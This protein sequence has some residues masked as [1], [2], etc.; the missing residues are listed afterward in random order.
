MIFWECASQPPGAHTGGGF[1]SD[2]SSSS[3][4][5][6]VPTET[7]NCTAMRV[8]GGMRYTVPE[9]PGEKCSYHWEDKNMTHL[10]YNHPVA[11]PTVV[12]HSD[13]PLVT[14]PCYQFIRYIRYCG[15]KP[16]TTAVC[17]SDCVDNPDHGWIIA[18]VLGLVLVLLALGLGIYLYRKYRNG[19][20][21]RNEQ[22]PGNNGRPSSAQNGGCRHFAGREGDEEQAEAQTLC[23][24]NVV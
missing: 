7:V 4:S 8:R 19:E 22:Q 2:S 21:G 14:D 1:S 11:A 20:M 3:S 13:S 9:V 6:M 12:S 23:N 16:P 24:G 10:A 18:L 5:S 17:T 15:G